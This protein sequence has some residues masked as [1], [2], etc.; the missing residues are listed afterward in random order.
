MM[1]SVLCDWPDADAEALLRR[2]AEAARPKGRVVMVN[3]VCEGG[4]AS[5]E[6]LMLVLV[7]GKGR[8]LEEFRAL[9]KRAGLEVSAAGRSGS[10]RFQVECV[11]VPA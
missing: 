6:L 11:P 9:A 8:S 7:G 3:D 5:P 4:V 2:C 10:G 1:K